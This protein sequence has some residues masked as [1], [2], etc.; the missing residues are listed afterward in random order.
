MIQMRNRDLRR[1]ALRFKQFISA[2]KSAHES[3]PPDTATITPAEVAAQ[4]LPLGQETSGKRREFGRSA[5]CY[6]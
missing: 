4:T 5:S 1:K 3:A 6:Y 2:S